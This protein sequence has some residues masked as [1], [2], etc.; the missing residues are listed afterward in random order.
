MMAPPESRT[1]VPTRDATVVLLGP[2]LLMS[3]RARLPDLADLC[4]HHRLPCLAAEGRGEF[5]QVGDDAVDAR[6]AG[7][8][9]VGG[10]LQ[11]TVCF[12]GVFAC[13]LG[14]ADEEALVRG[15]AFDGLQVRAGRGLLPCDVSDQGSAEIGHVFAA[16]E[17]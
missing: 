10:G 7:R 11:A 4:L 5:G 12:T 13:P 16:G 2:H 6:E 17:L 1:G 15:E 3:A 8:V 14:E 9:R